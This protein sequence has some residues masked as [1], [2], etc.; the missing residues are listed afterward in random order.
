MK[1]QTQ[2]VYTLIYDP[3]TP[4][5]KKVEVS[6]QSYEKH[7]TNALRSQRRERHYF[8]CDIN[9]DVRAAE[10]VTTAETASFLS[11]IHSQVQQKL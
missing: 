1:S 9:R 10:R 7:P 3:I 5:A 4:E 11:A 6:V 8:L 2:N